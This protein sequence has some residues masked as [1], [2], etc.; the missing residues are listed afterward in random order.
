MVEMNRS[1]QLIVMVL[2]EGYWENKASFHC[3]SFCGK[4]NGYSQ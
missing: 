3:I 2:H 1:D 4:K